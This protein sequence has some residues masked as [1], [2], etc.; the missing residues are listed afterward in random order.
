[1]DTNVL[2]VEIDKLLIQITKRDACQY[3]ATQETLFS[4]TDSTVGD[5]INAQKDGNQTLKG[6]S[7]SE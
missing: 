2:N 6:L 1:M 3:N 7:V 4:L 5:V